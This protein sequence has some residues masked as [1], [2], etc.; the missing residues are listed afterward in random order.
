MHTLDND[1]HPVDDTRAHVVPGEIIG[2]VFG[3]LHDAD[4]ARA[5]G[6]LQRKD[7]KK[8]TRVEGR[9]QLAVDSA[10]TRVDVGDVKQMFVRAALK[11]DAECLAYD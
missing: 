6:R 4:E 10:A 7:S 9:V 2:V 11:S 8:V 1:L 5:S 3:G